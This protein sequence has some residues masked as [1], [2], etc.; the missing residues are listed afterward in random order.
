MT[1]VKE[2]IKERVRRVQVHDYVQNKTSRAGFGGLSIQRTPL[3]TLVRIAAERPGLVIG[4][5]GNY[6]E[7]F[8]QIAKMGF[9][10]VRVDGKIVTISKN[11][12]VDR[13]SIHDIE[14]IID[15]LKVEK[16]NYNRLEHSIKLALDNG[17]HSLYIIDEDNSIQYYSKKLMDPANF[18]FNSFFIFFIHFNAFSP[19][20]SN[21]P[22]LVLGFHTPALIISIPIDLNSFD[23]A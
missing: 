20:P 10:Q 12:E 18:I 16:S 1:V 7:L 2:M 22:G 8:T 17:D 3:G 4:R 13:Y 19:L 15:K 5:K 23:V 11:M 21:V 9:T 6:R 14:I